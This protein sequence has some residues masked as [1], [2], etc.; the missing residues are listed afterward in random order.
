MATA[1][2]SSSL[3][4][5]CE[6]P[7][8]QGKFHGTVRAESGKPGINGKPISIFQEQDPANIKWD[9]ACKTVDGPSGKL[10]CDVRGAAQNIIPASTGAAKAVCKV[11]PQ[12]NW[13][14]TGMAFCVPTPNMS[15]VKLTCC[16]EKA[17]QYDDIK[18]LGILDYTKDQ[19]VSCNFNSDTH[20][21]T[22]D[23]GAGIALNDH[24]VKLISWYDNE[25][26]YSNQ[27]VDLMVHMASKE[28]A[29]GHMKRW[30]IKDIYKIDGIGTVP[31][32]GME[33]G[34][35]TPGMMVTF[36]PVHVTTEVKSV[37]MHHEALSE[38]P[39]GDNVG[40]NV[41]NVSV[42]DARHGNVAGDSKNYPPREAAGFTAQ[43][44]ER[45]DT[46]MLIYQALHWSLGLQR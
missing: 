7:D 30:P 32:G 38:A 20:S 27:V 14:L 3:E 19:V 45:I 39:L 33:T 16:L 5:S 2:L 44:Y 10:W 1:V 6:L 28:M 4:K 42:K 25:F 34:V 35:L 17:V 46:R 22:F 9:D 13:K 37:E 29:M 31:V 36:A 15:V 24:S 21:Y 18:N 12:L 41:K 8:S 40:F 23:A 11:I 26:G 43:L